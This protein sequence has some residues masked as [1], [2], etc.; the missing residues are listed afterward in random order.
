MKTPESKFQTTAPIT[1]TTFESGFG[2][3][4]NV[5]TTE[6]YGD[7]VLYG[8]GIVRANEPDVLQAIT[9]ESGRPG[10]AV[11]ASG[12]RNPAP[13]IERPEDLVHTETGEPL[14]VPRYS[15]AEA[16]AMLTAV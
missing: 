15:T 2:G 9:A 4:V 13:V 10:V 3:H 16:A 8:N 6:G 14:T 1:T 7:P 11:R 12:R 5:M